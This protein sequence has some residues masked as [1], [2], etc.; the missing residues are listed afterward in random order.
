MKSRPACS[1]SR[2]AWHNS[3]YHE[4]SSCTSGTASSCTTSASARANAYAPHPRCPA[5]LA[6]RR[7]GS[8]AASGGGVGVTTVALIPP[9]P[10]QTQGLLRRSVAGVPLPSRQQAGLDWRSRQREAI[11]ASDRTFLSAHSRLLHEERVRQEVG[12][13]VARETV[14]A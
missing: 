14:F 4:R 11:V 10:R 12:G 6:A 5:I 1:P 7:T 9:W 8:V 13:A 3:A 2:Q